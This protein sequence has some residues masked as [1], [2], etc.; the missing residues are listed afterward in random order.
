M[1]ELHHI[2]LES[3]FVIKTFFFFFFGLSIDLAKLA[4]VKAWLFAGGVLIATYLVRYLILKG[5][6]IKDAKL[7]TYI[8]PRGLIS[9]LLFFSIP[10]IYAI[11]EIDESALLIL[12]IVT[13]VIMTVG[14][15]NN[16]VSGKEEDEIEPGDVEN[17]IEQPDEEILDSDYE[18]EYLIE[19]TTEQEWTED[20]QYIRLGNE[21]EG[22]TDNKEKE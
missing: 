2:T 3:A 5:L 7:L 4:N 9:I 19:D 18:G 17:L 10:S 22:S 21:Q 11:E 12:I 20:E 13:N 14:L 8:T 1:K 16:R 6:Q 15:V